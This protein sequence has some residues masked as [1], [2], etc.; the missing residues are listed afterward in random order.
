MKKIIYNSWI[1]RHLLF[2][3]LQHNHACGMG[4]HEMEQG[5]DVADNEES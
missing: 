4:V 2:P 5:R 1:A 3:R